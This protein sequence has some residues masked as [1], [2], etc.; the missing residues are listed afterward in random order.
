[1]Q[2]DERLREAAREIYSV[3][4][5]AAPISFEEAERRHAMPYTRALEAAERARNC[6]APILDR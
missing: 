2:Q 1:M 3:C 6:L 5:T 4:F